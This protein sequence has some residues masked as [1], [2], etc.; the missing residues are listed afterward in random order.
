MPHFAFI[1]AR[2]AG[3]GKGRVVQRQRDA[4]LRLPRMEVIML[5]LDKMRLAEMNRLPALPGALFRLHNF[6]DADVETMAQRLV[7]DK[8]SI[9]LCLAEARTLKIGR[10]HV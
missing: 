7:T 6:F 3:R 9:L 5:H 2:K 10:A 1:P 8:E 4:S